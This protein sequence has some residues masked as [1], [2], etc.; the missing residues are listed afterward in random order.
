M[1]ESYSISCHSTC[2]WSTL[3]VLKGTLRVHTV[4]CGLTMADHLL[5]SHTHL[6]SSVMKLSSIS[7]LII[8]TP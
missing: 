1:R 7:R 8:P 4:P 2:F 5:D 6:H 3:R